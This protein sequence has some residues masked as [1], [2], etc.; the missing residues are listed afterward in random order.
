VS[1]DWEIT[2][3]HSEEEVFET[4]LRKNGNRWLFRG[5]P[6]RYNQ[7]DPSIDRSPR[8]KKSRSQKLDLERQSISCLRSYARYFSCIGEQRLLNDDVIAL[9]VLRH[10]GVPT[11]L[12]DWSLSPWVAIFFAVEGNDQ[13]SGKI[14]AFDEPMYE[15]E[16]K[17]QWLKWPHTTID[18]SGDALQFKA[19][20]TAF[21][22]EE[23]SDWF[24]CGFYETGFHR[25]NVQHGAYTM[26]AQFSRD[27]AAA[28]ANLLSD[29]NHYHLYELPA[30]LKPNLRKILHE[31]YGICRGTL[32]PDCAGAAETAR[33]MIFE[34]NNR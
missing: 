27:H 21:T 12:L 32:F 22:L 16:G 25:Q 29:S 30:K 5:Q 9:M 23:P 34:N 8:Q 20:L 26:T 11:R 33:K 7:L 17:K 28:I 14:W 1:I 15:K 13:E 6:G 19:S 24:I 10:Y 18:G 31:K 3:L 2:K 4:F